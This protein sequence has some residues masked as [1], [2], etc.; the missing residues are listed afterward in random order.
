MLIPL[1]T[2]IPVSGYK[3][4]QLFLKRTVNLNEIEVQISEL[5]II[6]HQWQL[7]AASL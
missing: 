5:V 2:D 3:V 6:L 7:F 1:P 4:S